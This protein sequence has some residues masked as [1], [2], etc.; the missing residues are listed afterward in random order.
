MKQAESIAD[1]LFRWIVAIGLLALALYGVYT[2]KLPIGA[3]NGRGHGLI[4]HGIGAYVWS[5]I[6][7]EGG[8]YLLF[9]KTVKSEDKV[10]PN[11]FKR[12]SEL[13]ETTLPLIGVIAAMVALVWITFAYST[14]V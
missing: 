3:R 14:A 9:H 2:G 5:A 13:M 7:G 8:L 4:L 6:L 1:K 12:Q 10:I 11:P